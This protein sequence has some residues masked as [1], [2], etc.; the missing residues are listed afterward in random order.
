MD[1]CTLWF[2][3]WWSHC[4]EQHDADYVAQIGQAV[5]DAKLFEC[6]ATSAPET[7]MAGA[8]LFVAGLMFVGVRV[9]GRRFY[10]N[11]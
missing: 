1:Y 9:F 7:W 8:S 4:C 10:R 11:T 6:V 2:E 3:G 5:A